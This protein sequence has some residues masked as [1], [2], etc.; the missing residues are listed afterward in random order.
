MIAEL[1]KFILTEIRK[2]WVAS[3]EVR[4]RKLFRLQPIFMTDSARESCTCERKT[5]RGKVHR[6]MKSVLGVLYHNAS[7]YSE[8]EIVFGHVSIQADAAPFFGSL[9]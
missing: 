1:I 6:K 8:A 9:K 5:S 7:N 2:C 3:V 4:A